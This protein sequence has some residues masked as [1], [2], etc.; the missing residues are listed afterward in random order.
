MMVAMKE[1]WVTKTGRMSA[2]DISELERL[3]EGMRVPKARAIAQKIGR[4][5][6]TVY[7]QLMNRGYLE[8]RISYAGPRVYWRSGRKI[9]RW[10]LEE[11]RQIWTMRTQGLNPRQIA[12][13][14]SKAGVPRTGHSVDVRLKMLAAFDWPEDQREAA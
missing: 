14:I 5:E 9:F 1:P 13:A 12:E 4:K 7:W 2:Q 6:S 11:D 3:A 8:H 10:T